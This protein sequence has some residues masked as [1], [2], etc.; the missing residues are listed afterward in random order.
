[1]WG[2]T[3]NTYVV[4]LTYAQALEEYC[5][6]YEDRN[7]KIV[8][9]PG[10]QWAKNASLADEYGELDYDEDIEYALC[11]AEAHAAADK[12]YKQAMEAHGYT[13]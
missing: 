13:V 5:K 10:L 6:Q 7:I 4:Q 11:E 1:M 8:L 12:A 9:L 2:I 3:D